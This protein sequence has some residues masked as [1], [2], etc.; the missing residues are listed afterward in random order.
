MTGGS[1]LQHQPHA[2]LLLYA[3]SPDAARACPTQDSRAGQHC[4][5]QRGIALAVGHQ[6]ARARGTARRRVRAGCRAC[7]HP[8]RLRRQGFFQ[9]CGGHSD[10]AAKA[11]C[12]AAME[13]QG[14]NPVGCWLLHA[15]SEHS[16][17]AL[18][19]R[20]STHS[21]SLQL[22]MDKQGEHAK[23]LQAPKQCHGIGSSSMCKSYHALRNTWAC[24]HTR[25]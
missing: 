25:S 2:H 1:R 4:G 11:L 18:H 5:R 22:R 15:G 6:H 20:C 7:G 10:A 17:W 19:V 8:G 13:K 21:N 23:G 12:T 3:L 14:E 24:G 9:Q 16:A